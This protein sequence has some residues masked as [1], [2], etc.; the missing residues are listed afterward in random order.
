[1]GREQVGMA[2]REDTSEAIA[3]LGLQGVMGRIERATEALARGLGRDRD[4]GPRLSPS[5][6]I[7]RATTACRSDL[8][9]VYE[10]LEWALESEPSQARRSRI[11]GLMAPIKSLLQRQA[12]EH[13]SAATS[14]SSS[15]GSTGA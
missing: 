12:A 6:S 8:F 5:Q 4:S 13:E 2:R 11:E 14:S 15:S 1:M 3:A 7:R 10:Q 9:N